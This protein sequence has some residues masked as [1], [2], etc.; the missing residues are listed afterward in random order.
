M[1]NLEGSLFYWDSTL[2]DTLVKNTIGFLKQG[3]LEIGAFYN[4]DKG[5]LGYRGNDESQLLPVFSS[6]ITNYTIYRGIKPDWVW[7]SSGI[8][9]KYSGGSQPYVPSGIYINNTFYPTGSTI[10]GTGY[11]ID[12]SRGRVIFDN[13]LNSGYNV[14]CAYS[15]RA[16]DILM[17][18]SDL[19][20]R[21]N[22]EWRQNLY[23]TGISDNSLY[24]YLP[25]IFVGLKS[26][27]SYPAEL[28]SRSKWSKGTIRFTWFTNN[29]SEFRKIQDNLY[30]LEDKNVNFHQ[31]DNIPKPLN[32]R[33][34]LISGFLTHQYLSSQYFD[35][36]IRFLNGC[37]IDKIQ[38]NQILPLRKGIA[39]IDLESK[40]NVIL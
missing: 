18:D 13:P 22:S 34:E 28:G 27:K 39:L 19:Y 11:Y 30:M 5:Q 32:H 1:S 8:Q 9:L 25:I 23:A 24:G 10:N 14:Q 35:G 31:I 20:R 40:V 17:E 12:F 4:I 15:I 26:Y 36:S 33:G 6:G 7:E 38:N 21:L 29:G 16:I 3:F 37:R 2:E